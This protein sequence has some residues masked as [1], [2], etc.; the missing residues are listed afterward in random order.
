MLGV[1][2]GVAALITIISVMNGFEGELRSRLVALTAHATVS[3]R[4]GQRPRLARARGTGAQPCPASPASRRSSTC[5]PCSAAPATLLPCV[6]HGIEPAAERGRRTD[7]AA[8]A[9]GS[10]RRPHGRVAAHDHRP[11]PRLAARCRSGRRAHRDGAGHD[12][13]SPPAAGRCC[14]H[15]SSPASSRWDCRITTVRSRSSRSRTR[16][17]S[18]AARRRPAGLRVRFDDVMRRTAARCRAARRAFRRRSRSVTG[19]RS[20][21]RIS[22]RS[23]SR[24]R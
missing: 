23:A 24:R 14:R 17:S 12:H 13:C 20:T 7:R 22:A 8:P 4:D 3:A 21:P 1:C 18:R 16:P 5:R 6:L 10:A 19:R 15:S 2:L 11:R 9:R